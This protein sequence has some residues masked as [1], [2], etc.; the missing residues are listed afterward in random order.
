MPKI[1]NASTAEGGYF[2]PHNH[3]TGI[4]PYRVLALLTDE[5]A[6][7][8]RRWRETSPFE[9]ALTSLDTLAVEDFLANRTLKDMA[10][11]LRPPYAEE[12]AGRRTLST[13]L[14]DLE[15]R[16][17]FLQ[18]FSL[19]WG[20]AA[21]PS[22]VRPVEKTLL[23]GDVQ[24]DKL[25]T[26]KIARLA[27][28]MKIARPDPVAL[29]EL[30]DE[31]NRMGISPD[32][33]GLPE[34]IRQVSRNVLTATPRNDFDSA[35]IARGFLTIE[36]ADLLSAGMRELKRQNIVYSEQSLPLW[37]LRKETEQAA[38]A[39]EKAEASGVVV[40]WLP[41]LAGS[42]LGWVGE[43]HAEART[44]LRLRSSP[45]DGSPSVEL[46][47]IAGHMPKPYSEWVLRWADFAPM[48]WP[49]A[50]RT[51]HEDLGDWIEHLRT[52]I[53][54]Q[55]RYSTGFDIA[56]PERTW[57][58]PEGGRQ[59]ERI[60]RMTFEVAREQRRPLVA[61]IHVG[62]GY[63]AFADTAPAT[64]R[65]S[66]S[67][68]ILYDK[69]TR[70]P[71]HY[72]CAENNVEQTLRAVLRLRAALS[73]EEGG[74]ALTDF[75][76]Y[77]HVRL[78]HVTHASV[79]QAHQMANANIWA[80]VNLTSNLATGVLS[81]DASQSLLKNAVELVSAPENASLLDHHA[82]VTLLTCGVPT[83]LGTDGSGIE[84]SDMT[85]EYALAEAILRV[86][87]EKVER[88]TFS[89]L[90]STK[91]EMSL[92]LEDEARESLKQRLS[93]AR[94]YENQALHHTWTESWTEIPS[95]PASRPAAAN[96][97]NVFLDAVS[98]T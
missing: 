60:L 69:Q 84:H 51:M 64:A 41:M 73:R 75:D 36:P 44:M 37:T 28:T 39:V 72:L 6:L 82:L 4:L 38:E 27:A 32:E 13:A 66:P 3:F 68:N 96:L 25:L 12:D 59:L 71:A 74:R 49:A 87:A 31:I 8:L 11:P 88:G 95:P 7:L 55:V 78:G 77:V 93:I 81:V 50:R 17:V 61:H 48:P 29:L 47:C 42:F 67:L 9:S 56:G 5:G 15:T 45:A 18:N 23:D 40:R 79:L 14:Y 62:E 89:L 22:K 2:D 57:Y 65:H 30:I 85:R 83:V 26:G 58:T 35:Y 46:R 63:P 1:K 10:E 76:R 33:A 70:L 52:A 94:L 92:M 98:G 20:M 90:S 80:D 21:L 43:S 16:L 53:R 34:V 19:H 86:A 24:L 97:N 54:H 91:R